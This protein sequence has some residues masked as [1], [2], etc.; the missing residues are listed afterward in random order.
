MN[1][2]GVN[3]ATT[4]DPALLADWTAEVATSFEVR[5][6]QVTVFAQTWYGHDRACG[7]PLAPGAEF[8]VKHESDRRRLGGTERPGGDVVARGMERRGL[9]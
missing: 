4:V 2:F 9:L 5:D 8:C 7:Q 3:P 6:C 1:P